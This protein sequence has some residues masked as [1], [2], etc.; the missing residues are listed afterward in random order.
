VHAALRGSPRTLLRLVALDQQSSVIPASELSF[1]LLVATN[2]DD[3]DFP[4]RADTPL[5]ERGALFD[6]ARAALPS[7]S[8]GPFGTWA[9]DFGTAALCRLWP[10]W[11]GG[12]GLG[13]GPLPDVPVI[14]LAGDRDLRTPLAGARE[15]AAR[16]THADLTIV[17]GVGHSVLTADYTGCASGAVTTWL[18]GGTPPLQ[19]DRVAPFV[20]PLAAFPRSVRALAP[21]GG[22]GLPGRT[23]SA[24]ARTVR[25]AGATWAIAATGFAKAPRSLAGPY[26][27]LL[28]PSGSRPGFA[29]LRYSV[30][31]GVQVSGTLRLDL[32]V[33]RAV[34]PFRFLGSVTVTGPQAAR[35]RLEIS[36]SSIKGRLGGRGVSA[37]V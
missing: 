10:P 37:G 15:V 28:R 4:W 29:L 25:E 32:G 14:V 27:G 3:G 30:V 19:C 21:L 31:P 9:T 20:S 17:P 1:G 23:L 11:S 35:G 13:P 5:A 18:A 7:G 12:A 26:G 36:A 24:V 8:T 34:I 16:F 22:R 6:A 33:F 2:C